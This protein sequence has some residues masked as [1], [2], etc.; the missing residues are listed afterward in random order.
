MHNSHKK[1]ES[2]GTN[3]WM[4]Q[5]QHLVA[6]VHPALSK[7]GH[8]GH[9]DVDHFWGRG[10]EL[11]GPQFQRLQVVEGNPGHAASVKAV[12]TRGPLRKDVRALEAA[13]SRPGATL[14]MV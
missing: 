11:L 13:G 9:G 4:H 10:G 7:E 6:P 1:A 5:S 8:I 3:S 14:D 12:G 2:Y